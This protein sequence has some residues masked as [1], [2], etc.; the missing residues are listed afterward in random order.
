M[1]VELIYD[2]ECPNTVRA[3]VH[4]MKALTAA[5][6]E[7]R[8]IEWV[9][10]APETPPHV[11]G[12]GSP[13]ILVDGKDVAPRAAGEAGP[14]C[15]LYRNPASGFDGAPPVEQIALALDASEDAPADTGRRKAQR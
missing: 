3:R 4:L 12:Y 2:R 10:G 7:A 15:R 8:W 6:R 11:Q 14:S 9:L 13:T 1:T 5:G